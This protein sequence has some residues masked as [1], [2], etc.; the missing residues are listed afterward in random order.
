MTK[1]SL[2]EQKKMS[3]EDAYNFTTKV[4]ID[5]LQLDETK[6]GVASFFDKN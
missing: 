5:N 2:Y 4:M 6:K 1:N 3:I